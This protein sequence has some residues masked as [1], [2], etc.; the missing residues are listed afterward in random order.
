[1]SKVIKQFTEEQ[2]TEMIDRAVTSALERQA[3]KLKEII[4]E[5]LK[6]SSGASDG[7]KAKRAPRTKKVA[8]DF[9]SA[10]AVKPEDL[11]AEYW[12]SEAQR[13]EDR[14]NWKVVGSDGK[15]IDNVA[16]Q[17]PYKKAAE[18]YNAGAALPT[19]SPTVSPA[20][21]EADTDSD[22]E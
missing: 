22:I 17:A 16:V 6:G 1:M 14:K 4:S 21:S 2:V 13:K 20:V 15:K 3:G 5:A 9:C 12:P 11:D 10:K 19:V 18:V 7:V 8:Y